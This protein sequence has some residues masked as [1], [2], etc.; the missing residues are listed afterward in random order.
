MYLHCSFYF[1]DSNGGALTLNTDNGILDGLSPAIMDCCTSSR[2]K[3][4]NTDPAF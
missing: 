3:C 2:F 4:T 1:V